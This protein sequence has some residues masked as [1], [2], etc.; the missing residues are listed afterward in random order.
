MGELISTINGFFASSTLGFIVFLGLGALICHFLG[1]FKLVA[2][3]VPLGMGVAVYSLVMSM[4]QNGI[5]A[6]IA[7]FIVWAAY[8]YITFR[9]NQRHY[10]GL[11]MREEMLMY[12][13]LHDKDDKNGNPQ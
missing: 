8:L 13:A 10:F 9:S 1:F 12:D 5:V 6:F 2:V 3:F 4:A 7:A 11:T